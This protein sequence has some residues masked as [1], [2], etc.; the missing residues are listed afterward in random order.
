MVYFKLLSNK[1]NT[2]AANILDLYCNRV[3]DRLI[4]LSKHTFMQEY[5][6]QGKNKSDYFDTESNSFNRFSCILTVTTE[7]KHCRVETP[8]FIFPINIGNE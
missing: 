3:R 5:A 7:K 4:I 2:R 8:T 1:F 6:V